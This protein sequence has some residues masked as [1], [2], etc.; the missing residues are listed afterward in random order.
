MSQ[1]EHW[2]I[3]SD[4]I[5]YV[6]H[7]DYGNNSIDIKTVNYW[8]HKRMYRKMGKETGQTLSIDFGENPDILKEIFLDMYEGVLLM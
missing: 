2:S 3:L 4:N 8:E 6:K 1:M 7:D 5:K